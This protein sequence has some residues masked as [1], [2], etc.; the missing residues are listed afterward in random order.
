MRRD[1]VVAGLAWLGLT[2]LGLPLLLVWSPPPL[3]SDKGE[4]IASAFRF[5]LVA[6]WPVFAFVLV[7]LAY[8]LLRFR[9]GTRAADPPAD[10]P[11]L[12]GLGRVPL[13]WFWVTSSL[14]LLV[15]IYPGLIELPK[16][17]AV[18][19]AP[20][21][22]VEVT[23]FQWAW[24]VRYPEAGVEVVDEL[25]LPV[26]RTARVDV[27][28][29]DVVHAF[30]VPAFG[31]RIDALPGRTTSL[32]FRPTT[33]GEYATDSRFRLQCSQ[34]CGGAHA[35]MMIPVR[36]VD[37]AAF[38]A[39]L[40]ANAPASPAA[41]AAP[42]GPTLTLVARDIRF[43][44]ERLEVE[45]GTPFTIVFDNQD[46]GVVHNLAIYDATGQ[47]VDD[48]RTAF[49][50]GPVEQTLTVP[51][52]PGGTYRFVCDAHPREMVGDLVVK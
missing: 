26:E 47:L 22:R 45:A 3:L 44:T 43:S 5:L 52:L 35:A 36:V 14:A 20:D 17:V 25:V 46:A 39:W 38:G 41:S 15:M 2:L 13:A 4:A 11:A 23:A 50:P 29:L 48:A 34:L 28:S 31:L 30:W 21:L 51:A 7:V 49:E 19:P 12:L 27:T 33:T 24:R 37:A 42:G 8:S 18:D 1:A 9:A 10:G 6:A 16:V 40:A 32:S